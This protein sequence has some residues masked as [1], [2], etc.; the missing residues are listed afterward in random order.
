[1]QESVRSNK[2]LVR[3]FLRSV[4][5]TLRPTGEAHISLVNRRVRVCVC[6]RPSL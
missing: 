1:M 6:A 2:K 3:G 5:E 4:Q